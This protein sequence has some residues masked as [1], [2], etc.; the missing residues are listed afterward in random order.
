MPLEL[1][2]EIADKEP[3]LTKLW[4]IL[5][6]LGMAGVLLSRFRWWAALLVLPGVAIFALAI[7]GEVTDPHVGPAIRQELGL[8]YVLQAIVAI[9]T[10]VL[11]PL[12]AAAHAKRRVA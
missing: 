12:I 8:S 3:S 4:L 9:A 10:G 1:L 5:A 2:A 7:V 11:L 6:G